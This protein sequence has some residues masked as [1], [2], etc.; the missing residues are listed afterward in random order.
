MPG[1]REAEAVEEAEAEALLDLP[2]AAGGAGEPDAPEAPPEF[3]TD[4]HSVGTRFAGRI[5][6]HAAAYGAGSVSTA[7]AAIVSVAVFTRYLDPSEFGKMAV[8][9][10]VSMIVTLLANLTILPGTMRRTYGTTGDGEIDVAD[11]DLA[12]V[13]SA[14]PAVVVSTGFAMIV[15]LG[16]VVLLGVWA[17]QGTV[18]ELFGAPDAGSLVL[19]AAGAGV[20]ASMMRFGQY[21]LRMQLRSVAYSV[22]TLVYAVGG[23]AIAIPLLASGVGVEAVLIGL[24]VAGLVSTALGLFLIRHDLKPAVSLSEAWQIT[25]GGAQFLPIILSF[26][27]LQLAD[28]LFVAGFSSLAQTGLYGVARKIALPV[29]FGTGVFQQSWGPMRHDLT[30]AAVDKLDE[31][32]EYTA[33]LLTYYAVF[34]SALVLTVSVLADQL[35][36][37]AGSGFGDAAALVPITTVSVA[38][39]GWFVFAYRTARTDRKIRWLIILST[40]A[41]AIFS[42]AAVML[43]PVLGAAGAPAAAIVAW[44]IATVTMVAIGQRSHPLPLEYAKLAALAALT[45]AAWGIAHLLFPNTPLGVAGEVAALLVW[46]ASLFVTRIVPF[47]EVRAFVGYARHARSNDSKRRLRASI[48]ELDGIDAELVDRVVRR[49][50]PPQVVAAQTGMSADDVMAR[51]VHALR[52]CSHGGEPTDSDTRLGELILVRRPHAERQHGLQAMVNEGADPIDADLIMRAA[53][54]AARSRPLGGLRR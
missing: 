27:T 23:V 18:A 46:A 51:T 40:F 12:A 9:T 13:V 45:L 21:M 14:D 33:R 2:A 26:Q 41:A 38:G 15:G 34:V 53:G 8:L 54:A 43:I 4:G 30:Q 28:T 11:E 47:G 3:F 16:A 48:A 6:R 29:S 25:R 44:G 5:G 24:I 31:G 39:H 49:K 19:L 1:A 52:R 36:F 42:A 10:T 32:G 37:L 20:A 7:G 17:L 22:V 35:V 50:Q